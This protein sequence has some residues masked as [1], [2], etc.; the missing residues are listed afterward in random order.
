MRRPFI[1]IIIPVYNEQEVIQESLCSL[2]A[3]LDEFP[4]PY[5]VTIVDNGSTDRT[6]EIVQTATHPNLEYMFLQEKGKGRAIRRGF[7][8][9]GDVLFFMDADL[10]SDMKFFLPLIRAVAEEGYDISIGNRLGKESVIKGRRM[11]RGLMSQGYNLFVRLLFGSRITDHQCGFKAVSRNAYNLITRDLRSTG[12]FFDTELL[13]IAQKNL[14][15]IRELD[16]FWNDREQSKVQIPTAMI[17]MLVESW[18]LRQRLDAINS[19]DVLVWRLFKF[20]VSGGT[21]SFINLAVFYICFQLL[22]MWYMIAALIAALCAIVVS[23]TLQKYW[24]FNN[25]TT[26]KSLYRQIS[27]FIASVGVSFLADLFL[28]YIFIEKL[29][30]WPVLAQ[31]LALLILAFGNF[32]V[33]RFLI[34]LF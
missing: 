17:S 18:R 11:L 19:M 10:S 9:P 25:A 4:Y 28:L 26:S 29:S 32:F 27:L 1:R 31:L 34:F 12:W 6:A 14:L 15:S 3:I 33:Y 24:T 20:F 22:G 8:E 21:A 30:I 13:V 5:A 16:I 7:E 2:Y 23:F